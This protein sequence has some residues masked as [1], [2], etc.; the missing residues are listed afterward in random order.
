MSEERTPCPVPHLN[1]TELYV[2]V[3]SGIVR[4]LQ[5]WGE[6]IIISEK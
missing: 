1:D 3:E 4:N 6:Y 2:Q 5:S